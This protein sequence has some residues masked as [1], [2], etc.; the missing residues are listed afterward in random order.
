MALERCEA[1]EDWEATDG[2]YSL[3]G[4]TSSAGPTHTT[5]NE[6]VKTHID[7]AHCT[8]QSKL[9]GDISTTLLKKTSALIIAHKNP[10][11]IVVLLVEES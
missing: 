4:D 8:L 7:S 9:I 11:I 5:M 1:G 2:N 6:I 3:T 10:L